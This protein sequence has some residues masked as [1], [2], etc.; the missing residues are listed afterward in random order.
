MQTTLTAVNIKS[1]NRQK[2]WGIIPLLRFSQPG[3]N[4]NAGNDVIDFISADTS[5]YNSRF[6]GARW[7]ICAI[8]HW[9]TQLLS[10]YQW[11]NKQK[12]CLMF[13]SFFVRLTIIKHSPM[14]PSSHWL[15]GKQS[16]RDFT[17]SAKNVLKHFH[18][19]PLIQA[20]KYGQCCM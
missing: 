18:I 11:W 6:K 12:N 15:V 7:L 17:D 10:H 5:T 14:A 2:P 16:E 20:F 13:P 9:G 8:C 4:G 1:L 19:G 3:G